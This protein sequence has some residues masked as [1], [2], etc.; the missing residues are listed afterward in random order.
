MTLQF[1]KPLPSVPSKTSPPPD[2]GEGAGNGPF[3]LMKI[4]CTHNV[5]ASGQALVAG[6]TYDVS[7]KDA[8][9]LITM[10]KAELSAEVAETEAEPETKPKRR[11]APKNVNS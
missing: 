6:S 10:G 3:L 1:A 9:I 11:R 2:E 8:Q 7:D 5:M 4:L